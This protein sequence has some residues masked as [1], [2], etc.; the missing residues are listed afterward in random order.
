MMLLPS[1]QGLET[2]EWQTYTTRVGSIRLTLYLTSLKLEADHVDV[3]ST[4]VRLIGSLA[5]ES[6]EF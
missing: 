1:P 5:N 3:A 4:L 2:T 6:A